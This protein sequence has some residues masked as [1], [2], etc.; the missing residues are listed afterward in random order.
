M[1]RDEQRMKTLRTADRL[2][3]FDEAGARV[4]VFVVQ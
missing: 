4:L 3:M 2:E 1:A